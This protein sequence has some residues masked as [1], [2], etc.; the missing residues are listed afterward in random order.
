MSNHEQL[1]L[2]TVNRYF[3]ENPDIGGVDATEIVE[4]AGVEPNGYWTRT[5]PRALDALGLVVI[6]PESDRDLRFMCP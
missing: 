6:Y 3:D 2:D 5:V 4:R 1:I